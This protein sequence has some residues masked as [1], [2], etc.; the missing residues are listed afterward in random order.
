MRTPNIVLL[1][2]RES[3]ERPSRRRHEPQAKRRGADGCDL[4][5]K[6]PRG[7]NREMDDQGCGKDMHRCAKS[8]DQVK[9]LPLPYTRSGE[10]RFFCQYL[11]RPRQSQIVW[12]SQSYYGTTAVV[13]DSKTSGLWHVNSIF[14][15]S[16]Q[17]T[18]LHPGRSNRHQHDNHCSM[19]SRRPYHTDPKWFGISNFIPLHPRWW[20]KYA[21][22]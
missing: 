18:L 20:Y 3:A 9:F 1:L 17:T 4:Q 15:G 21:W 22:W 19:F 11:Y 5:R 6:S 14:S 2:T 10:V 8:T 7:P 13:R 16:R 12:R